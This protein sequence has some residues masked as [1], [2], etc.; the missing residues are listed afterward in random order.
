MD[1]AGEDASFLWHR[2]RAPL[3]SAFWQAGFPPHHRA[4][5]TYKF[6]CLL[7]LL[8]S[9][10]RVLPLFLLMHAMSETYLYVQGR[11]IPG[12]R[13]ESLPFIEVRPTLSTPKLRI[14]CSKFDSK[15]LC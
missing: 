10:T 5:S 2:S 11:L 6:F 3:F 7:I 15:V 13:I 8:R 1:A 4:H 9:L 14:S 12:A